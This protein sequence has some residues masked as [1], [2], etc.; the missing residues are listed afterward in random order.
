MQDRVAR[1]EFKIVKV[2][3]KG[4]ENAADGLAKHVDTHKIEQ[5]LKACGMVRRSGRR[6]L[7]PQLGAMAAKMNPLRR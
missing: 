4:K 1:V 5:D 7:S 3:V 6:D 2:K